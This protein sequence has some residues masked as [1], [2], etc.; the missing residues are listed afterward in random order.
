M[1]K[2]QDSYQCTE[3]GWV[4]TR[5]V[6]RCG[7]C[8]AWGTV[9]ERGAPK[10]RQVA[11]SVP[12]DKAVPIS[13]V[14][15]DKAQRRRT[16]I[17]E[18]DR[19]LGDGLVPGA[20]VLLAG[21]PGVGKSTL[22]LDVAAKWARSGQT[23]LYI[24]GEESASQVRLRA[25]RTSALDDKL[26]L[27]SET[28]LGTVLGH[29]EQVR[30]SLLVLDS[31]QTIATADAEGAPGGPAQVREVTGALARVAKRED[32]AVVIVGHV[33]KDG[34]IAGPRTLEHLVDVVLTFEGD[35]HS[36]F[37]MVRAT[38]N[39][40]G[41]A[42]EVGCFEMSERGI[43]EVPDPSGLFTT[44]H[45]EPTPG[46]CVTVTL[47]GRRPLL[48]EIQAL[49]AQSPN[50]SS[51]RRTTHGL[52]SS[53]IAMVLAVLERKANLPLSSH[54]VYVST[55]GGARVT[56]PSVDLP[57]AVAVASAALDR[58]FPKKLLAL[59]EVG[60][61]GDLRRVPGVERRLAE[62]SR[63]GFELAVVP[64]GSRDVTV[65]VPKLG[66]LKVVEVETLADALGMLD[67]RRAAR[68]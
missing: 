33:T 37:R 22:L 50:Q 47:E 57:V 13:D 9:A 42:D 38:K 52:D 10:L 36:G 46:T 8:Q 53:R 55:V 14:A 48:A 21:E 23:T 17:A 44:A 32:M 2:K 4:S 43:V 60:L 65:K 67:L 62:A 7:E 3:C 26:Y 16:T 30:P 61:A 11:S 63:L 45:S 66:G 68:Q 54:D 29:I 6:G 58:H 20:V 64:R 41:P 59:G 24:S 51:P 5:W 18:L 49:V 56:D 25:E 28:D 31:V 19:V 15:T 12:A 34:S 40:F 27:A 1:A 39:R 35:R